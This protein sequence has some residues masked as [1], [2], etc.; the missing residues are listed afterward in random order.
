[1]RTRELR[2]STGSEWDGAWIRGGVAGLAGIAID[3]AGLNAVPFIG[4]ERRGNP[5]IVFGTGTVVVIGADITGLANCSG[6]AATVAVVVAVAAV[7][8]VTVGVVVGVTISVGMED[9]GLRNGS[10]DDGNDLE[11]LAVEVTAAGFSAA[12]ERDTGVED[13]GA[14]VGALCAR[15]VGDDAVSVMSA[16]R[17]DWIENASVEAE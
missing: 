1:M 2:G 11:L 13:E 3:G 12:G 14:T 17:K 16:K 8:V 9:G 6:V 15:C 7:V 10:D 4:T 5:A